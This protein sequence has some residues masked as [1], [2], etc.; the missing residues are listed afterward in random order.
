VIKFSRNSLLSYSVIGS[1]SVIFL[2]FLALFPL[3]QSDS[4]ITGQGGGKLLN[5][6]QFEE[7]T[8]T[9]VTTLQV[10]M[11]IVN[12]TTTPE[13]TTQTTEAESTTEFNYSYTGAAIHIGEYSPTK[14]TTTAAVT[15]ENNGHITATAVN[16]NAIITTAPLSVNSTVKATTTVKTTTAVKTTTVK[17]ATELKPITTA[18]KTTTIPVPI[19]EDG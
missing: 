7:T 5:I 14:V 9:I 3:Q 8:T 12:T 19:P 17:A 2:C 11:I 18:T 4:I 6:K 1:L 10:N 13:N 15:A 16:T